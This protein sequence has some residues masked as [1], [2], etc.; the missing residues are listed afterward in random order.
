MKSIQING[1]KF[2]LVSPWKRL[3]AFFIDVLFLMCFSCLIIIVGLILNVYF[4]R[5]NPYFGDHWHLYL[6]Y[7]NFFW[8][9][10]IGHYRF[11]LLC[12]W[13]FGLLFMD[14]YKSGQ[15]PGKSALNIQV[16]RLK[17][18][19]PCGFKDAFMR[20]IIGILQPLDC[21]YILGEKRQRLGDKFAKTVVVEE[22]WEELEPTPE[23][24][25]YIAGKSL[26]LADR[27]TRVF[28]FSIDVLIL[29]LIT[30]GVVF[31]FLGVDT[32][33]L[34]PRS[35]L[36]LFTSYLPVV[37]NLETNDFVVLGF[38]IGY[39]L[40]GLF[41]TDGFNGQ[42]L[43]KRVAGIQVYRLKDGR[44]C[45]FTA[46]F[47]RRVISILQPLDFFYIFGKKRQRLGDKFAKTV[48]AKQAAEEAVQIVSEDAIPH[49]EQIE[50]ELAAIMHEMENNIREAAQKVEMA[51]TIEK[52]FQNGHEKHVAAAA[53]CHKNATAALKTGRED[54][55]REELKKRAEHLRLAEQHKSQYEDQKQS[56]NAF[57]D[58][59]ASLE[60]EMMAAEVRGVVVLA[61][62]KNIDAEVHL[63]GALKQLR[64][65]KALERVVDLEQG[66]VEDV[67][68]A[69]S[70]TEADDITDQD[71][72]LEREL[73]DYAKER[74]ID[75]ELAALYEEIA[76]E[77]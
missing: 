30:V 50:E 38:L 48:V 12:L 28:A 4:G 43:G 62:H 72:A 73:L 67:I 58:I 1:K 29:F 55:A 74:S 11:P 17:D 51:N 23:K 19:Q 25:I 39:W 24:S 2:E 46:A 20:R 54:L 15:S 10:L 13:I 64:N 36:L 37:P 8:I 7:K 61:Q 34:E 66:A 32:K 53:R 71:K 21:F 75:E 41:F 52:Q 18:G 27:L 33:P 44:P 9:N 59:L 56:V 31:P 14:G 35:Y 3:S 76:K 26:E 16:R 47:M 5:G 63:R 40:L 57:K 65:S 42:S 70:M 68:L 77:N 60:Y 69:K 45:G 6:E 22:V 49:P